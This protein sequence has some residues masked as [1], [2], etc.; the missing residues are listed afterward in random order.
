M[1]YLSFQ[2]PSALLF[3]PSSLSCPAADQCP[4][5]GD[6]K[7]PETPAPTAPDAIPSLQELQGDVGTDSTT[8][9][10]AILAKF[11]LPAVVRSWSLA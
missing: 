2:Q 5:R 4:G 7:D 8:E 10:S 1:S 9:A 11:A 6:G 3:V